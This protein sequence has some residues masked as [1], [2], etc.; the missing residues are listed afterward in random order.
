MEFKDL[1]APWPLGP[2]HRTV[3]L[4][5][6]GPL[7]S[8]DTGAGSGARSGRPR[9][10]KSKPGPAAPRLEADVECIH[11]P[12]ASCQITWIG[13]ASFL[14]QLRGC[15]LLIDPVLSSRRIGKLKRFVPPGLTLEQLPEIHALLVTHEHPD[16]LDEWTVRRLPVT[17]PVVAPK[18][19]GA[20][21]HRRGLKDV[22]E[23]DWWQNTELAAAAQDDPVAVTL[24]PARHGP[25]G[26]GRFER[27]GALC[28]GFV[29]ENSSHAVYHSGDTAFF[30]GF[31]RLGSQF[32]NL[33]A[34]LLPVGAYR[35]EEKA[36]RRHMTPE[37][38]GRAF[39]QTGAHRLIPMHWGTFQL[40]G[41]PLREGA[42]RLRSWWFHA[43]LGDERRLAEMA[44]GETIGWDEE[45]SPPMG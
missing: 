35:R 24:T 9:P 36:E 12:A 14:I 25:S 22:V 1:R 10:R 32:P 16:H 34:A 42:D 13:H 2:L 27:A 17:T 26:S 31:T 37:E 38:A 3:R 45:L 4:E 6:A 41:E 8:S 39:L 20:F 33:D 21:F 7:A 44:V 5:P 18:G 23:L 43:A 11:R 19:L 40:A 15:N 29:V 28:G 30:D